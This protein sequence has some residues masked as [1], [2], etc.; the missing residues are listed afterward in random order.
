MRNL[1]SSPIITLTM[2]ASS[3]L[4]VLNGCKKDLLVSAGKPIRTNKFTETKLAE[5]NKHVRYG[6]DFASLDSTVRDSEMVITPFGPRLNSDVHLIPNGHKLKYSGVH[7]QE[8]EISTG[9][10]INDFGEQVPLKYIKSNLQN[11]AAIDKKTKNKGINPVP[12]S[13]SWVTWAQTSTVK[14]GFSNGYSG[15]WKVPGLPTVT[16]DG[17]TI[18]I[19]VGL[20][21]ANGYSIV[22]PIIQFG[23]NHHGGSNTTWSMSNAFSQCATCSF[24][25]STY[26][27]VASGATVSGSIQLSGTAG[28]QTV[29]SSITDGH[30]SSTLQPPVDALYPFS[31]LYA[32]LEQDNII[33][34]SDYPPDSYVPM[35]LPLTKNL[36][37]EI[38]STPAPLYGEHTVVPTGGAG[39]AYLFFHPD[40]T[41]NIFYTTPDVYLAGTAITPLTP[42]NVGGAATSYAVSPTLPAGL[43]INTSTGVISGTPITQSPSTTYTVTAKNPAGTGTTTIYITVNAPAI[44][45]NVSSGNA[46]ITD[47]MLLV[48]GQNQSGPRAVS[49][50]NPIVIAGTGGPSNSTVIMQVTFGYMPKSA[51]IYAP[52]PI[53]GTI[54]GG[55]VTFN[56]V[57]L[58]SPRTCSIVIN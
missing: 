47:F 56:G 29:I 33:S 14:G 49:Q 6:R 21:D 34:A 2:I 35:T 8:I 28:S 50:S 55:N 3:I 27:P 11:N 44:N 20:Q 4:F 53:N 51:T 45:F 46:A 22:Q 7:L 9:K 25:Y 19:F 58:S 40:P 12:A 43:S 57:D 39:Y 1:K 54:S 30:N 32:T 24:Y 36:V 26:Y 5:V 18:F 38:N 23:D 31:T 17:Q 10:L 15:N 41:P 13:S 37:P 42:T 52:A 48:N 16:T